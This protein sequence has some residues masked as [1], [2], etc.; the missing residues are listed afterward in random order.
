MLLEQLLRPRPDTLGL[1]L[2]VRKQARQERLGEGLGGLS[3][4][5]RRQVIDRDDGHGGVA[6]S[7]VD[8]Y[9]GG[10]EDGVDGVDGEGVVRVGGA[11]DRG[12]TKGVSR[13]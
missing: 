7:D 9:G 2:R 3:G 6:G 10:G 4:E 1:P 11:G 8:V 13:D 5:E 12:Q